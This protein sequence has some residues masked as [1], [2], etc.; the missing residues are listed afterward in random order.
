MTDNFEPDTLPPCELAD[1]DVIA[2][3]YLI[4]TCQ[5]LLKCIY[6]K[7]LQRNAMQLDGVWNLLNLVREHLQF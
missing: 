1:V 7:H 2:S 3:L 6:R 5:D 4:E